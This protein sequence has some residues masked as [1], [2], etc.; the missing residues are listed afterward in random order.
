MNLDAVMTAI[1]AGIT[2]AAAP[3]I[4]T[5]LWERERYQGTARPTNEPFVTMQLGPFIE[6]GT[7]GTWTEFDDTRDEG[8]EI[9]VFTLAQRQVLLRLQ[10]WGGTAFGSGSAF[11]L[12]NRLRERLILPSVR[13]I[14]SAQGVAPAAVDSVRDLSAVFG[15]SMESRALCDIR[16]NV[17][18][19]TQGSDDSDYCGYIKHVEITDEIDAD[20]PVTFTVDAPEE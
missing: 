16:C 6:V 3:K 20:N 7:D 12:L 9:E 11:G 18:A 15:T 17:D 5:I 1:K 19:S 2:A 4:R 8:E 10:C 14:F 13:D